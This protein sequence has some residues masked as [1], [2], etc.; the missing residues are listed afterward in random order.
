MELADESGLMGNESRYTNIDVGLGFG[1]ENDHSVQ[2]TGVL[3]LLLLL[4]G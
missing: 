3:L 1:R 4:K 2:V